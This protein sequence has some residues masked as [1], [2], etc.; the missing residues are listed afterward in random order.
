MELS[1]ARGS[2][3]SITTVTSRAIQEP[4][5]GQDR[6][7]DRQRAATCQIYGELE[8]AA[9][10]KTQRAEPFQAL[11][12]HV[13]DVGDQSYLASAASR[14]SS[15]IFRIASG[16]SARDHIGLVGPWLFQLSFHTFSY[17][18]GS[19]QVA[20]YKWSSCA[21]FRPSVCK[22]FQFI[23]RVLENVEEWF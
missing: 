1:V 12:H 5:R 17:L 19:C 18:W 22:I 8:P 4:R 11:D 7:F 6:G 15:R 16:Q 14:F 20:A 13:V 10:T 9:K 21:K 2:T 3:C 23:R